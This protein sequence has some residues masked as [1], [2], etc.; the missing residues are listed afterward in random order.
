MKTFDMHSDIGTNLYERHLNKEIDV[1]NKYH[2]NNLNKGEIKGVFAAC[3]FSGKQD[4][5]YMQKMILNMNKEIEENGLRQIKS[6]DDLIDDDKLSILISVEGMCGVKDDVEEKIDWMYQNGVR[7][8][9]LVWNE[10][11]ELADGWPNDVTRGIS[12][13]GYRVIKRMNELKMIIDVSHINE[14]GFWDIVKN[15]KRPIIATHSNARKLCGH[16]RNLTDQ[17]IKAIGKCG[18]LIGLNGAKYFISD[19]ESM[20]DAYHLALHAK[21]YADLIGVEHVACGFDYMDFLPV[22]DDFSADDMA[23]DLKDASYTQNL[24]KGLKEVGFTDLEV[25]KI[26]YYNVFNFLK[27]Q[28]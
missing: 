11:N 1:F 12:E 4:F 14:C 22:S 25:S 13:K 16:D 7:V 10:S 15:S 8:A 27:E 21:Y 26:A 9:S 28:L 17:Q 20:Q 18:G 6:V 24:I 19:N 3:Y 23:K 5:D 2:L